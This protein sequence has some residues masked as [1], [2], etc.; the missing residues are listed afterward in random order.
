MPARWRSYSSEEESCDACDDLEELGPGADDER[1]DPSPREL[2]SAHMEWLIAGAAPDAP[3]RDSGEFDAHVLTAV[4]V[5]AWRAGRVGERRYGLQ[6][7]AG[8]ALGARASYVVLD[9]RESERKRVFHWLGRDAPRG[10]AA[11]AAYKAVELCRYL[12]GG[13]GGPRVAR[14]EVEGS[15]SPEFAEAADALGRVVTE[16][17]DD[18]SDGG[19]AD[20]GSATGAATRSGR[21]PRPSG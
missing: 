16:S 14:R 11:A 3:R 18:E 21:R 10:A 20:A 1:R 8:L 12:G 5:F 17:D 2:V 19:D 6:L 9:A 4:G 7:A 15:E 13:G